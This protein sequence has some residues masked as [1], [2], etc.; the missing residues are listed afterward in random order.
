MIAHF[1]PS[2]LLTVAPMTK[3]FTKIFGPLTSLGPRYFSPCPS[4]IAGLAQNTTDLLQVLNF[5]GLLQ[6][7]IMS[8]SSNCNKSVKIR[9]VETCHLQICYN[10]L[11]QLATSLL[12][13]RYNNQLATS[14]L[15][16]CNRL[17]VT[18]CRKPCERILISACR[19]KL[20]QDVNTLLVTTCANFLAV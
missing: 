1:G 3:R 9:I 10:L 5:T 6:L 2:T 18:S 14:L 17:V 16:T 15:T 20:L 8:I 7:V 11:K 19:N 13:A 12:M 4:P